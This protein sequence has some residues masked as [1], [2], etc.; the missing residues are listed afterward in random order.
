MKFLG[1]FS[2]VVLASLTGHAQSNTTPWRITQPT[3]T[4]NHER[5]FGEFV[6]RI[7]EAVE[8]RQCWKVDTCLQSTANPYFGS[9]PAGL[10]YYADCADLPYY[11]RAYFSWKNGLPFSIASEVKPNIGPQDD[12]TKKVDARYSTMGNYI[13]KRYD[14]ITK[15]GV[16]KNT[17]VNAFDV[18]NNIVPGLTFSGSF[19]MQGNEDAELFTDFYPVKINREAIRPGTVIYDP[20]GHVA[21]IYKVADDGR[22]FYIDAHPDNSLTMGMYT[23]K[24]VRSNPA[25]GAGFKNFRPLA[26]VD[27]KVDSS[28]SYAGGKIV[29]AM[30]YQLPN[31]GLEQFYGTEP[32]SSG[33]SKGKFSIRGQQVPYYDYVRMSLMQGEVHIDPLK[34]MAQLTDDI[35]VSLKDRVEAVEAARTS[36]VYLKAHPERL[37]VNIYGAEGE[38]EN[39]ATPSRDAR[40][41]VAFADLLVSTK[42]NIE[43]YKKRDPAIKYNGGNLAADLF[44]VYAQKA[45][46]CQFTY[47]TTNGLTVKMNLEAA[48]QRLFNMSFDP[49]HCIEHRWGAR[50]EQELAACT[51]DEN[52]RAWYEAEKWLRYQSERRYDARMDYSLDQL[53]GPL[54]GAGVAAPAD[55]DIV[56]YLKS[57]R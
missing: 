1:A 24:F 55:V 15:N 48:R 45:Q 18:L 27:A 50:L 20:N 43:R 16:F 4:E 49:Y 11:L 10:K 52:K 42:A 53:T 56:G 19:R 2:L 32:D 46:A 5:Q 34:D 44:A 51:D 39:F 31:Y 35:C 54:P 12:P 33:W 23:P 17:H 38:W 9:D 28:G 8:K 30:N 29:A 3:W 13:T 7:G 26:L 36:G 41:K 57:Q 14:V 37:P 6:T 40:L 21:I 25:Q 22:I 47:T